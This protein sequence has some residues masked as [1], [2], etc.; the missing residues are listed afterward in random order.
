MKPQKWSD[1]F[2]F[3]FQSFFL[4]QGYYFNIPEVHYK[5]KK[6]NDLDCSL[7]TD[8]LFRDFVQSLITTSK[9]SNTSLKTLL[10]PES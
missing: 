3:Y 2:N 9:T 7:L 6:L 10:N 1:F 8:S 5:L 4:D